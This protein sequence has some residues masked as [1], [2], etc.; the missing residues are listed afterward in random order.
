MNYLPHDVQKIYDI[1]AAANSVLP[2]VY[3]GNYNAV[4]RHS[5]HD[6]FPL[7]RKLH[8]DFYAYSPIAGGFLA[9]DPEKLRSKD[10]E[11][12]FSGQTFLGDMYP[13]LCGKESMYRALEKWRAIANDAGVSRAALA[14]RWVVY[15]SALEKKDGVIVGASRREQLEETLQAIQD[16]PLEKGIAERAGGI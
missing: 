1:Q 16:G 8:I 6:L 13:K 5:E 9:K 15:H 3:Q 11:G 7:L 2:T 4:A 14:Y 10:V 12:R